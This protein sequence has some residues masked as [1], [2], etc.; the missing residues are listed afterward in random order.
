MPMHDWTRV[1][2]NDYHA[3]HVVWLGALQG[4]LNNGILPPG[5]FALA[6][7]QTPPV[8]ADVLTLTLPGDG[9]EAAQQAEFLRAKLLSAP[10]LIVASVAD[11]ALKKPVDDEE[12]YAAVIA[13]IENLLL[14]ATAE[15]LGAILRTGKTIENPALKRFLGLPP[16]RR[17]AGIVHLGRPAE[18]PVVTRRPLA[19]RVSWIE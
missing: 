4:V 18:S 12:N 7:R 11:D 9:P 3:L 19:E 14:A 17:I 5:Y 16:E 15:G 6:E 10:V 1:D 8:V 2:A 13:A